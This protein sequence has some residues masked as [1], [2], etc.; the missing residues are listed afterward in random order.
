MLSRLFP[1]QMN[2]KI[3]IVMKKLFKYSVY[4]LLL[5][6]A[7]SV[8]SCQEEFE[9]L[10]QP[11]EQQTMMATSSTA[12]LIV[13]TSSSDGSFDNI[14]DG[15]SCIAIQFP[16]TVDVAGIQ[17]TID[18]KE[19]LQQ[20]ENIL[21]QLDI[22]TYEAGAE[23][24]DIIFPITVTLSDYTQVVIEN[25]DDLRTLAADCREGG[26]DDDIECIDFV[27]PITFYT[28]DLNKQQT[29]SVVVNSDMDLRLFFK[30]LG[31][32]DLISVDFPITL[33]LYDDSEM[34]VNNNEELAHAIEAA[35]LACDEDDDSDFND[36]D[37][38]QEQLNSY[39]VE[40][41]WLVHEVARDNVLQT[42]Q[43]I[44]Y[45]MNFKENG[46]VVV[47][48]RAGNSLTGTWSTRVADHKVLVKLDFDVLVDFNL[49]WYVY[50]I[51]EGHIKF[52]SEGGNRIVLYRACDLF[53][54]PPDN[55]RQILNQCGWVIGKVVNQGEEVRRLIGY[56]FHFLPE[57][58]VTLGFGGTAT[59]QGTWEVSANAQGR[60]VLAITMET[61]PAVSFEWP[62]A[63]LKENRL[64]F[65]IPEIG[66]ELIMLRV[67][68]DIAND[69]DV[70]EIGNI[71][72]GGDWAVA[73]HAEG[74]LEDTSSF[75][76]YSFAF[77]AEHVLAITT[78]DM[79]PTQEGAWRIIRDSEGHL[80]VYLNAGDAD[81]LG[82]LTDDW[83]FVSITSDRLELKQVNG[84]GKIT[85]LVFEKIQL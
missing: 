17:I 25:R 51:G 34:Q 22:T 27:Y 24:M 30:N 15:A 61:D 70:S 46:E 14:V 48:D 16:Y 44:D 59:L 3:Q 19:D 79:G 77:G 7:L 69:G 50:E 38:T 53:N 85:V 18:S 4:Y 12:Q 20:I 29:G 84:E 49:E 81:P 58:V 35:K 64:K 13:N 23:L 76:S 83:N 78:G 52:V 75:S 6:M 80:K 32:N 2:N 65:E 62:L 40:C 11:D 28:F 10:P 74:D 33:K 39:L 73:K 41:P 31:E 42:D 71:L 1:L 60:L 63:E 26:D 68:D 72:M 45:L 5:T 43:Y 67:C 21:D 57:G 56:E 66:Y 54:I 36:D 47:K 82:E 37:F 9:E 8:T 55:L